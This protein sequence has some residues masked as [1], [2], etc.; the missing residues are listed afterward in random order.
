MD[1]V[2]RRCHDRNR[3]CQ[4]PEIGGFPRAKS[5]RICLFPACI[6]TY[7]WSILVVLN[8]VIFRKVSSWQNYFPKFIKIVFFE[9]RIFRKKSRKKS[10]ES[11]WIN[12]N[13]K[14]IVKKWWTHTP[15]KSRIRRNSPV[16]VLFFSAVCGVIHCFFGPDLVTFFGRKILGIT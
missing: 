4:T 13:T 7:F 11:A 15:R 9:T 10:T 14:K 3:K 1:H 2:N 16:F 6:L 5:N 12:K 8:V